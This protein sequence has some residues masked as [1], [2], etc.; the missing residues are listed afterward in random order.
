[1]EIR[2][3]I[4][5]KTAIFFA[6]RKKSLS[7]NGSNIGILESR[8][9]SPFQEWYAYM[10]EQRMRVSEVCQAGEVCTCLSHKSRTE[11]EQMKFLE[12]IQRPFKFRWKWK[13]FSNFCFN[14]RHRIF[15]IMKIRQYVTLASILTPYREW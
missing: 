9:K 3:R 6:Q 5:R 1:M 8:L 11:E 15:D 10:W 2:A 7:Y 12:N 14:D 13:H 4:S